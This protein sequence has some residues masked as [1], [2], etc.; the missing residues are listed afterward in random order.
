MVD[1]KKQI[2]E[3][4]GQNIDFEFKESLNQA[5][6]HVIKNEGEVKPGALKM[7]G[8]GKTKVIKP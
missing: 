8:I 1:L 5:L 3:N 4:P 2:E 7:L 6:F